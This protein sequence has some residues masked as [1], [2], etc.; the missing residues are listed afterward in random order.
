[1]NKNFFC[2]LLVTGLIVLGMLIVGYIEKEEKGAATVE[3]PQKVEE[4]RPIRNAIKIK[5][6]GEVL[7]YR[8]ESLWNEKDF[9]EIMGSRNKFESR[10]IDSFKRTLKKYNRYAV[11][12]RIEFDESEKSTLLIC[13][14][15]GAKE[16]SWFDFDWFLRP[17]GL[18]F[19][20]SHFE[21]KEKE[22]YWEGKI[23]GVKTA[24]SIKFSYSV[25]NCH[26]HVWP[27]K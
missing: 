21:R 24:I 1:M 6:E 10:E 7:H 23:N 15:K 4:V 25:S 5:A 3:G 19:I 8:K 26:E 9:S 18:D 14:I 27:A 13:D 16:G 22:L 17:Y 12:P 2:S 20:D 11:T